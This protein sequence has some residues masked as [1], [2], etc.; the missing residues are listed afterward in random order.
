[1]CSCFCKLLHKGC[2]SGGALPATVIRRGELS[3]PHT[4]PPPEALF[5]QIPFCLLHL[6]TSWSFI[7]LWPP[8][9]PASLLAFCGPLSLPLCIDSKHVCPSLDTMS[10]QSTVRRIRKR[11]PFHPSNT[12][13]KLSTD[14]RSEKVT[15]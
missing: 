4:A 13:G 9:L 7:S 3:T 1:M 6:G 5:V 10:S 12:F 11:P 14:W 8:L 2:K 15:A